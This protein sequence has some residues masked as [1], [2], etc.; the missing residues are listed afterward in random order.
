MSK[1]QCGGCGSDNPPKSKY[2]MDCG[3]FLE[4]GGFSEIKYK[5]IPVQHIDDLPEELKFIENRK[6][7]GLNNEGF[8]EPPKIID[9]EKFSEEME[10]WQND[11][12]Y[13]SPVEKPTERMVS[14]K[15]MKDLLLDANKRGI[16]PAKLRAEFDQWKQDPNYVPLF[17]FSEKIDQNVRYQH[18]GDIEQRLDNFTNMDIPFYNVEDSDP[19]FNININSFPDTQETRDE[20]SKKALQQLKTP[21][22]DEP[23]KLDVCGS[24]GS[25]SL[26]YTPDSDRYYYCSDCGDINPRHPTHILRDKAVKMKEIARARKQQQLNEAAANIRRMQLEKL[27]K[28]SYKYR[29]QLIMFDLVEKEKYLQPDPTARRTGKELYSKYVSERQQKFNSIEDGLKQHYSHL[30]HEDVFPKSAIT[31]TDVRKGLDR[32]RKR[33]VK[34][35]KTEYISIIKKKYFPF[36]KKKSLITRRD[37]K[38]I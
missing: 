28:Y 19:V 22:K 32:G 36:R 11:P 24:C 14:K 15:E 30:F 1:M 5:N 7:G 2:C 31:G 3:I 6:Q 33:P 20:L 13:L 4:R 12:W 18:S 25:G 17:D 8:L 9:S 16:L 26:I 37:V 34:K 35:E 21:I 29:R 23:I 10:K 38:K 27:A